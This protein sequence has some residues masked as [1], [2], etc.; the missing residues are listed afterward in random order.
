MLDALEEHHA[1]T[2]ALL[3]LARMPFGPRRSAK[4]RLL[5]KNVRRHPVLEENELLPKLEETFDADRRPGDGR[6][7]RARPPRGATRPHPAAPGNILV[8]V[9]AAVHDRGRDAVREGSGALSAIAAQ[10]AK[11]GLDAALS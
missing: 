9:Y 7:A 1:V 8:S 4:V 5:E 10:G 11:A 2:V 6:G 3:E